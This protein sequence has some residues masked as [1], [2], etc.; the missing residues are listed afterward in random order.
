MASDYSFRP[1]IAADLPLVQRWLALPH[2][3]QWWR[4]P[5]QQYALISGDLDEPNMH[6]FIFC[7]AGSP[8]GYL[9]CYDLSDWN[10]GLGQQPQGARGIDLFIGEPGMIGRGHG[11]ALISYFVED[12]LQKG[13]PCVV[14][15]P[16]PENARAIRAYQ[17]AGF[18]KRGLVETPDG[19]ALLMVRG[20]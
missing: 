3:R 9:Q 15:D 6:Q 1:M 2:V 17:K 12:L 5:E 16:D 11:S 20:R 14:T 19:R 8:F 10:T 13:S 7:T 4:D 18:E